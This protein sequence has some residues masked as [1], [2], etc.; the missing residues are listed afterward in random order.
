[1]H[2]DLVEAGLWPQDLGRGFSDL[3]HM[4]DVGHYGGSEHVTP[5]EAKRAIEI[6]GRILRAVADANPDTF[7]GLFE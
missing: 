7:K 4:R 2:R 1:M 5:E 3:V 6:A